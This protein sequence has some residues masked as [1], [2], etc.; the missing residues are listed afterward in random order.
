M[1]PLVF[2]P[3]DTQK[4]GDAQELF[5][6]YPHK[7]YQLRTIGISK[8]QMVLYLKST[9]TNPGTQVI[10]LK[11][12]GCLVGLIALQP[13]PW[14]SD[15]FGLKMY[16]IR[17]LLACGDSPMVHTRLL[18]Y[19]IE[20]LPEVD[21]LDC[22]VAVDDVYAAHALEACG[23]RYVGAEIFLGQKIG[24]HARPRSLPGIN[25]R[26]CRHEDRPQILEIVRETHVHNRFVCDPVI[27]DIVAKSLYCRLTENS[28]DAE[29]F[30]FM[31][32]G[33]G[34]AVEGFI[35]LKRNEAFSRALGRF[36]GSLDL[37][38]VRPESR[39][40]GLGAEL[41]R[42]ALHLL[43]QEKAEFVAV[44]TL[45]SNYPAL[46]ICFQTGFAIT[47]SALFFHKWIRHPKV[48]VSAGVSRMANNLQFA[49]SLLS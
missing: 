39:N 19:A 12:D 9:L 36:C 47:S 20:E 4:D 35:T 27:D 42:A 40:R 48:S 29:Q 15:H 46:K 11:E 17:H 34:K 14:M 6:E 28:F 5:K 31:V 1:N 30:K 37:I 26:P 10:C 32:A 16:S 24:P 3:Y 38:G 25:F 23:F 22:R 8:D 49:Q 45:A 2:A 44:R 43:S 7:E 21:F 13:L 18:R 41:N 33:S